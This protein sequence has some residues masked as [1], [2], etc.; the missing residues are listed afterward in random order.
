MSKPGIFATIPVAALEA[1]AAHAALHRSLGP[2]ALT[3]LGI[4]GIIGTGIF[5]LTGIAAA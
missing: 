1:D 2:V 4:G 5:V 3:A